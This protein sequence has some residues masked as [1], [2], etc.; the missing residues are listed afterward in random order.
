[1]QYH[2]GLL[3]RMC[4]VYAAWYNTIPANLLPNSTF[5]DI[6][7][8]NQQHHHHHRHLARF[9]HYTVQDLNNWLTRKLASAHTRTNTHHKPYAEHTL[10]P[11]YA[12]YNKFF[13]AV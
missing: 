7:S 13:S 2:T 3:P 9:Q 10:G 8:R 11:R 12:D 6:H 5:T 1:M 4:V